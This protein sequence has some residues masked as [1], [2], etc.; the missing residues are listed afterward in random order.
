MSWTRQAEPAADTGM[1]RPRLQIE[2]VPETCWWSNVRKLASREQWDLM[3]RR[4]YRTAG[5][6]CELC[7]GR[8]PEHPVECHE[9]WAYDDTT[10]TQRLV[11]LLALCPACHEVKHYGYARVR[12]R[13]W[14][15]LTHLAR[16]NGWPLELAIAHVQGAF[17]LWRARSEHPWRLD[18]GGLQGYLRPREVAALQ[19]RA[20]REREPA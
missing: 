4:V 6:R 10:A 16:V 11:R 20:E 18:V 8:G 12:G 17:A 19:A 14:H 1:A 2:L 9:V 7:G 13:E 3:R 5:W 15:A